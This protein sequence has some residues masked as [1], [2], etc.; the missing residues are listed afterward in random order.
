MLTPRLDKLFDE[1]NMDQSLLIRLLDAIMELDG[2]F[3]L[4]LRLG[5]CEWVLVQ[6]HELHGIS[7]NVSSKSLFCLTNK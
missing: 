7:L 5:V 2:S 1:V 3:S 6:N 4:E